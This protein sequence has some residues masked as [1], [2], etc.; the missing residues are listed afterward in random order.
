MAQLHAKGYAGKYRA[1]GQ[2]IHLITV[3]FSKDSRI[4]ATSSRSR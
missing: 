4:P 2:P 1:S 3:E